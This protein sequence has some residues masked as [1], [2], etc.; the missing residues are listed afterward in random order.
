MKA[1]V[2]DRYGSADVL[3]L[4]DIE[5][6][7]VGKD[8]VLVRVRAAGA[9][10][11]AWHFMTGLP[12]IARPMI[13]FRG[14]RERVRGWDVAGTVEVVGANV[15]TFEVGDEVMGEARGSFAEVAVA[16]AGKLVRKP[17]R[18]SFEEAAAVPVSGVTALQAMRKAQAR[19]GQ[20]VLVIGASGG[21]GTLAVQIAK[22]LGAR[23]TG[24]AGTVKL[25]L[26]RSIGADEVIDYTR[27]DFTDGSRRWDV[28]IDTAGR[29]PLRK[30]R[31]ALTARGSLVIVGGDGGGRWTGGF[32]RGML[33][34]PLVSLFIGQKLGGLT[35]KL[36]QADLQAVADLVEAGSVTPVV[37]RTFD[38]VEAADAL[39]YLEQGHPRGKVVV[40]A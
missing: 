30:L 1:I 34:G 5:D 25:E 39:R 17:A 38:L 6:P 24:V 12:L 15:T 19:A 3:E 36:N 23:V 10:P 27:E 32:F 7:V 31:R 26:V 14:P 18:L 35:S 2:Q 16:E 37:D 13:G 8:E 9:G 28:I 21:V 20:S 29:R 4:R 40:T 22:A 33:R 11:D